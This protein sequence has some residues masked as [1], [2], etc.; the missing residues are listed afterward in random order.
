MTGRS[1]A[2][3]LAL[4]FGGSEAAVAATVFPPAGYQ[5]ERR[6]ERWARDWVRLYLRRDATERDILV[7]V[8]QLR[9]GV[10]PEAVQ[11]N[12]LASPEYFGR[13]NW[14]LNIWARQMIADALGR[15]ATPQEAA[16]V[17]SIALR[18]GR[19][20]A[21]LITLESQSGFWWGW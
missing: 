2:L 16:L 13:C 6:W 1:L 17:T 19:Y 7:I 4:L 20:A 15:P 14:N 5:P 21:A 11:A 10:S 3:G 12:I 9:R 8:N 18:Q